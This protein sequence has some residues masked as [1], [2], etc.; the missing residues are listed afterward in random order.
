MDIAKVY[1]SLQAHVER[2]FETVGVTLQGVNYVLKTLTPLEIDMV[3]QHGSGKGFRA[4]R[5]YRLAYSTYMLNG[6]LLLAERPHI[7]NVLYKYYQGISEIALEILEEATIN[8]QRRANRYLMFSE[9]Y[10]YTPAARSLWYARGG[11]TSLSTKYT[12][13]P[14]TEFLGTPIAL[15]IWAIINHSLD[16]ETQARR[17]SSDAL[18]VASASNPDGAQKMARRSQM[19]RTILQEKRDVLIKY[20]S[21]AHRNILEGKQAGKRERWTADISTPRAIAA[22][23][24]RQMSG[25]LDKHDL[26]MQTF[27]KRMRKEADERNR[28]EEERLA[29]IR[30]LRGAVPYTGSFEVSSEEMKK[31]ESGEI[32]HMDL[33][34]QKA[35][36]ERKLHPEDDG[37]TKVVSKRVLGAPRAR[38]R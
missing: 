33:A 32:T 24:T 3:S 10:A 5:L 28:V 34:L 23:L 16:R 12:G 9:G 17:A 20:G 15:E 6:Y 1:K 31:I 35:Q 22:E 14:G 27:Y 7:I 19:D 25:E 37:V 29:E 4:R 18:T 30:A 26:F 21:E 13:I 36:D 38:V 8:L 11:E 2:G